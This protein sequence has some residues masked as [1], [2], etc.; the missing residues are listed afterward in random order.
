MQTYTH[1]GKKHWEKTLK[2]EEYR[3][4]VSLI[5]FFI[6]YLLLNFSGMNILPPW[7]ILNK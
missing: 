7:K 3:L 4:S 2:S 6:L 1:A 5:V